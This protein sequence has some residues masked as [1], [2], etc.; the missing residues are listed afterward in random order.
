MKERPILFSAPM[1]RAILADLKGQT[2]RECKT[3]IWTMPDEIPMPTAPHRY[4]AV[5]TLKPCPYGQPGDRLWVRET[6]RAHEHNNGIDGI[7]YAA[8]GSFIPIQNTREAAERWMEARRE[9]KRP[10]NMRPSIFMP[11]WASRI[12]L[13]ITGVRVE[14]LQS[15]SE[16][17]CRSE[18]CGTEENPWYGDGMTRHPWIDT[19][20]RLWNSINGDGSWGENPWVWVVEFR[21]VEK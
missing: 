14:R 16:D 11:R 10:G 18:G 20:R 19:Y 1:V 2:R 15:I 5:S 4:G 3:P 7:L 9:G 13:E 12:T 8:D 17:D 6:W 21:R